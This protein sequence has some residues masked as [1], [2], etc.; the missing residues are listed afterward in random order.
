MF[1]PPIYNR[2]SFV[3]F[4]LVHKDTF[5]V[6]ANIVTII[7]IIWLWIAYYWFKETKKKPLIT[8]SYEN[9]SWV[10]Q[11]Q[12]EINLINWKLLLE[13]IWFSSGILYDELDWLIQNIKKYLNLKKSIEIWDLMK[14][15]KIILDS[16]LLWNE[17][18]NNFHPINDRD[19]VLKERQELQKEEEEALEKWDKMTSDEQE[20]EQINSKFNEMRKSDITE[21]EKYFLKSIQI[22]KL[23]I[24]WS[25]Y[26]QKLSIQK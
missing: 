22:I 24:T 13:D 16:Y 20:R 18:K 15:S 1:D 6:L 8:I 26:N 12:W 10:L 11:N 4:I 3:N 14:N 2:H 21:N 19:K 17:M 23:H 25:N 7:W 5:S 9:W